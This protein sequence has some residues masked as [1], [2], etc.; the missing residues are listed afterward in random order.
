MK[1]YPKIFLPTYIT[2]IFEWQTNLQDAYPNLVFPIKPSKPKKLTINIGDAVIFF[3][4]IFILLLIF[5]GFLLSNFFPKIDLRLLI[6]FIAGVFT[7][8]FLVILNFAHKEKYSNEMIFYRMR[9][10][11]YEREVVRKKTLKVIY[12]KNNLKRISY[13]RKPIPITKG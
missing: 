3:I 7:V 11:D 1:R 2:D 5:T 12:F 6:F 8:M 4:V 9:L 13:Y 10:N